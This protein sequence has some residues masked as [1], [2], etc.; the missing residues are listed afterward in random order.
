MLPS[1]F[2][3]PPARPR[4]P[5]ALYGYFMN[6][7]LSDI[8]TLEIPLHTIIELTPKPDGTMLE[9]R[10]PLDPVASLAAAQAGGRAGLRCARQPSA[11]PRGMPQ[12]QHRTSSRLRSI[13]FKN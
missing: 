10:I 4:L 5:R 3:N 6:K 7:P 11:S 1:S 2:P 8:P 12:E 9:E 13:F